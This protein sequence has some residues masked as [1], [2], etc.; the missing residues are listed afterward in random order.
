MKWLYLQYA[1]LPIMSY[2]D[3]MTNFTFNTPIG[4][5][6]IPCFPGSCL[7]VF[8]FIHGVNNAIICRYK[9]K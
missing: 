3:G 2:P 9:V 7:T 1:N 5:S 8:P 4:S 6:M